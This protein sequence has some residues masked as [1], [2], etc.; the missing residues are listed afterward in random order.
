MGTFI[1]LTAVVVEIAFAVFCIFTKSNHKEVRSITRIAAFI[2][3]VLFAVLPIIDWSF[4]YYALGTLLLLL[5]VI[6]AV[7]LIHKN[8]EKRVYKAVR[9]VLKAIGMTVLIFALTLPAIIFPQNKAVVEATGEYQ[10]STVTYTYTD[11][12]RIESYTDAGENRK[13]NVELWYPEKVEETY[14]LIVF[15]HGAFGI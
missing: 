5:A 6:G 12:S 15:S 14:P 9:V 7:Y 2:G 1:F 10:V 13:L 3:F 4:R 11:T 8:E